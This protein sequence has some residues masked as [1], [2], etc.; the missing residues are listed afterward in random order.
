MGEYVPYILNEKPELKEVFSGFT[1]YE[2]VISH[3]NSTNFG[4][5]ALMG[6]YE[7]TPVEMNKRDTEP[8]VSKH[9]EALKLMPVLFDE[10]GYNVTVCDPP[11]A[12]YQW[13]PDLSIYDEYP[14]I[15]SHITE[16]KLGDPELIG[17]MVKNNNR[18][19]F[20]FSIMKTLP[21]VIQPTLYDE[22]RYN[23]GNMPEGAEYTG[24]RQISLSQA[25]GIVNDFMV[26]YNVLI[27]LPEITQISAEQENT[28]LFL[29][30]D[31]THEP[32]LLQ[33]PEYVPSAVVDNREY[34]AQFPERFSVGG[35]V[36]N[37][38]TT[39][40]M[41]HYHANMASLLRLGEWFD[42]MREMGVYDNTRIIIA[43]D[44]GR[45]MYQ[46]EELLI[47]DAEGNVHDMSMFYPL[48]MVKDFDSSGFNISDEFMTNADVPSIAV[49]G[50]IDD[51]KNPF[52]GKALDNSEK[53]A[54]QQFITMSGQFKISVNNGNSYLPSA[55]AS[56]KDSIWN[57][58]NW[59]VYE[60]STVLNRN[61][62]P[63]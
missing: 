23:Q 55:W 62:F 33:A 49:E 41:A 32:M 12:N 21:L 61:E 45:A 42:Y 48:L 56:V 52:T 44:H 51:P 8:L 54:H 7:Y 38:D 14:N 18:N 50:L 19:L 5:P 47:E 59:T 9:N 28:F 46:S 40:Q 36:L 20:C 58:D 11:Y 53:F 10:Q 15:K 1:Y 13:I 16:G 2:N 39:E 27:H 63:N 37:V 31:T 4:I 43:S 22:G 6:G 26:P 25:E 57:K 3:G 35:R 29:A 60:E 30:N 24:Q 34:D 17:A